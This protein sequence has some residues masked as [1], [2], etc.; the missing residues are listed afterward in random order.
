MPGTINSGTPGGICW[1]N[2]RGGEKEG[3]EEIQYFQ[4]AAQHLGIIAPDTFTPGERLDFIVQRLPE[5]PALVILDDYAGQYPEFLTRLPERV[6]I[7]VTTRE[8]PGPG[9]KSVSLE[10]LKPAAALDMLSELLAN[11]KRVKTQNED[12][13][14]LCAWLGHLPLAIELIGAYLANLPGKSFKAALADLE[15]QGI[16]H[17][18]LQID[19]TDPAYK[20]ESLR[21][22][23]HK[24]VWAA[25]E[26]SRTRLSET[27]RDLA[28][29]LAQLG[30][31]PIPPGLMDAVYLIYQAYKNDNEEV[32]NDCEERRAE[33]YRLSLLEYKDSEEVEEAEKAGTRSGYRL[34]PLVREYFRLLL[35]ESEDPDQAE[36]MRRAVYYCLARVAKRVPQALTLQQAEQVEVL[37]PHWE[38]ACVSLRNYY[39]R[40][41]PVDLL[42]PYEA[43]SR[44]YKLYS[45]WE[46]VLFHRQACLDI[47]TEGL[48]PED[49]V[50]AASLNN[51]AALYESQGEY[52]QAR[53]LFEEALAIHKKA[54]GPEHPDTILYKQNLAVVEGELGSA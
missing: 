38:E 9:F 5:E 19:E 40:D 12:A 43:L 20:N 25:L 22:A 26:L 11:K 39:D 27:G 7:L 24:S 28:L 21:T 4:Y 16:R 37:L 45:D 18:A 8:N 1:L 29:L 6:R 48:K 41:N 3:N 13:R 49:P 15:A 32:E 52:E 42:W 10:V 17:R 44:Y 46:R 2:A 33:L 31:A 54:L 30:P 36:A 50:R 14:A 35:E 47:C 23:K 53:P 51:M 34:H